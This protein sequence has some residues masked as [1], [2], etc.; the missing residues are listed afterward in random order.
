M[1]FIPRVKILLCAPPPTSAVGGGYLY[2]QALASHP[3]FHYQHI[4]AA[5]LR[6]RLLEICD[7]TSGTAHTITHIL[8]DSLYLATP[9]DL[10]SALVALNSHRRRQSGTPELGLL[11]HLLPSQ[12]H[13]DHVLHG[14]SRS[15]NRTE[16]AEAH[17]RTRTEAA[18]AAETML[19]SMFTF[20]VAPSQFAA[21]EL[22]RRGLA[23][24]RIGVAYPA[25]VSR[26]VSRPGWESAPLV[27]SKACAQSPGAPSPGLNFLSVGNWSPRKNLAGLLEV[28]GALTRY[29]W[30]WK[31]VVGDAVRQ[32]ISGRMEFMNGLHALGIHERVTIETQPSRPRLHE[33][34]RDADCFVM[35][36]LAETYGIVFAE[37]LSYGCVVVA[38]NTPPFT[39]FLT[40]HL[41]S[42]LC[43]PGEQNKWIAAI[44]VLLT[45]PELRTRL[46]SHAPHAE[47]AS[48]TYHNT[49]GDMVRFLSGAGAVTSTSAL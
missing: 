21:R 4:A 26:P 42:L 34:Y 36:P 22:M 13:Q 28:F 17:A 40:P 23:A 16:A 1:G 24:S 38:P 6:S 41:N 18:E 30:S 32:D 47:A 15:L 5:A 45:D 10:S 49:A 3:A 7:K 33:L 19:L 43:H 27:A 11:A 8:L 39:E 37:A 9:A 14:N 29:D 48:R 46:Q 31:I 2:N 35:A 12:N 20:A 44:E 25:P